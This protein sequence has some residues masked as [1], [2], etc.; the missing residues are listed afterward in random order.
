M[1]T[2]VLLTLHIPFFRTMRDRFIFRVKRLESGDEFLRAVIANVR[3]L[4]ENASADNIFIAQFP[5]CKRVVVDQK[6][7]KRLVTPLVIEQLVPQTTS[8]QS[9]K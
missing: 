5:N 6:R 9:L 3:K 4:S 8:G 1:G 2:F 7:I